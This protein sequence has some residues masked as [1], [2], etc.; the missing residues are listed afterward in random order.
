M[1]IKEWIIVP[2]LK[3]ENAHKKLEEYLTFFH[4]LFLIN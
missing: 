3:K 4:T 1:I 2:D